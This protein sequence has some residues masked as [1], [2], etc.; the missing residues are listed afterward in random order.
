M[1]F[2]RSIR[3]LNAARKAHGIHGQLAAFEPYVKSIQYICPSLPEI[4][5]PM[6]IPSNAHF[7]GPILLPVQPLS[8][9]DP[10]LVK[11]LQRK[12]TVLLNLGSFQEGNIDQARGLALGLRVLLN[13]NPE[14]QVLWKFRP[15]EG[16]DADKEIES[17]LGDEIEAGRIRVSSWLDS[18]PLSILQSGFVVATVHHGGANSWFEATW[19]LRPSFLIPL[20]ITKGWN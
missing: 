1:L 13:S 2:D 10:D 15:A 14:V 17:I 8:H 20:I 19:Y 6:E 12:P 4:D 16:S 9:S 3:S 18:E 11:W 5:L 7:V